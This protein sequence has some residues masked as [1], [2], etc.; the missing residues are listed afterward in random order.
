MRYEWKLLEMPYDY[1]RANIGSD[2][3]TDL[4]K[5]GWRRVWADITLDGM[6]IVY[7]REKK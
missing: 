6:C 4:Y 5:E 3:G 7:R 2:D 1:E